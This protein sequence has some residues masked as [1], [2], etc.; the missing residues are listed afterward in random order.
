MEKKWCFGRAEKVTCVG[1]VISLIALE[2]LTIHEGSLTRRILRNL[3][4]GTY[5]KETIH[6]DCLYLVR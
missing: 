5:F 2:T 3:F 6:L 1:Y 4:Y